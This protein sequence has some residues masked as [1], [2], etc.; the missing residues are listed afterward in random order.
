[1]SEFLM[2]F[3]IIIV[4]MIFFGFF[5]STL[6]PFD[7]WIEPIGCLFSIVIILSISVLA[8]LLL[9]HRVIFWDTSTFGIAGCIGVIAGLV[10]GKLVSAFED[11]MHERAGELLESMSV[12]LLILG[13]I[14][15]LPSVFKLLWAL[16]VMVAHLFKG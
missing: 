7:D 3:F 12:S 13:I 1:M 4:L 2:I 16:F 6:P 14:L 5:I 11:R 10:I 9:R 15:V 8:S